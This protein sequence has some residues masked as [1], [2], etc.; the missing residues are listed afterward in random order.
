MEDSGAREQMVVATICSF[1]KHISS[2]FCVPGTVQGF[3]DEEIRE[4]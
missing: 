4:M 2:A 3:G 1:I